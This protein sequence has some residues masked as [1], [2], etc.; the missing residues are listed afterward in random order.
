MPPAAELLLLL[1]RA[2][3]SSSRASSSNSHFSHSSS[4]PSSSSS[5][6]S[7]ILS[8]A[9][10]SAS[11]SSIQSLASTLSPS[12][13]PSPSPSAPPPLLAQA[14]SPSPS[15][16]FTTGTGTLLDRIPPWAGYL[17]CAVL[18]CIVLLLLFFGYRYTAA[19]RRKN[20][21]KPAP[22][23]ARKGHR[24]FRLN[25]NEKRSTARPPPAFTAT[26]VSFP[27]AASDADEEE[28]VFRAKSIALPRG[29]L[30]N[31]N[32][33]NNNTTTLKGQ[34]RVVQMVE[35]PGMVAAPSPPVVPALN[36]YAMGH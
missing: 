13:S 30:P 14:T 18:A 24:P 19:Q 11:T 36:N 23:P 6:S 12:P 22:A 31:T 20:N 21:C 17:I 35:R 4:R 33:I 15:S 26:V 7:A 34:R 3:S 27:H 25:P 32:N 9:T 28:D 5:P 2:A 16:S 8:S 29:T 1:P 10:H